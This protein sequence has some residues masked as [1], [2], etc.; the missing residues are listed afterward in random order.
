MVFSSAVKF[1]ASWRTPEVF[2]HSPAPPC[3][4]PLPGVASLAPGAR[5]SRGPGEPRGHGIL[6]ARVQQTKQ[7]QQRNYQHCGMAGERTILARI[8][9]GAAG[10]MKKL[11]T[12]RWTSSPPNIGSYL[13]PVAPG[14]RRADRAVVMGLEL[15]RWQQ[16]GSLLSCP[17]TGMGP[18]CSPSDGCWKNSFGS[19]WEAIVRFRQSTVRADIK[20]AKLWQ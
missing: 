12:T 13:C 6:L 16:R 7:Q 5:G 9:R 15:T 19:D 10:P 14:W 1:S 17:V 8:K 4:P 11:G 18:L 2:I 3:I 20:E